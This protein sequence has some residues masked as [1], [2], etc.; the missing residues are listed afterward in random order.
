MTAKVMIEN[1]EKRIGVLLDAMENLERRSP[2]VV[3]RESYVG[4][5]CALSQ[6]MIREEDHLRDLQRNTD[7]LV[8]EQDKRL[9]LH[10]L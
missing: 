2:S 3:E 1:T 8:D 10:C 7:N 6:Q 5:L 4:K 9:K